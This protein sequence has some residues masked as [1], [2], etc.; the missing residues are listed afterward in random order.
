ML[1]RIGATAL[2]LCFF[3]GAQSSSQKNGSG[4]KDSEQANP[5]AALPESPPL[6]SCPAGTPLGS[7]DLSVKSPQAN[8]EALPFQNI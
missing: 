6:L 7:L 4:N 3:A 1:L 5:A 2:L 8:V